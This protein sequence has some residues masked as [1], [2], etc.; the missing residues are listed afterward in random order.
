[1]KKILAILAAAAIALPALAQQRTAEEYLQRYNM[2]AGRLGADGVGIETLIQN[3]EKDFPEDENMLMAKWV[4]YLSKSVSTEVVVM[5]KEKY[6][7]NVPVVTL[8]DSLGNNVNYFQK[9]VFDDEM[10]ALASQALDQAIKQNPLNLRYRE[11]KISALIVYEGDSPDMA[12]AAVRS[13]IDYHYTSKPQWNYDSEPVS[14]TDFEETIQNF[15]YNFFQ[16]GSPTGYEAFRATAQKMID[17]KSKN[18]VFQN[19]LGS[20]YQVVK[21]DNKQALKY[22]TKVLKAD[23]KNYSA[24]KNCVLISRKQK[25]VK[26]EKKYLA[27]L[28]E[29]SPDE[30]ER[31]TAKARLQALK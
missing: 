18:V 13:L 3:W 6:L 28:A 27:L 15:C 25:N 23:P 22:Y 7:G 19:D 31:T 24:I 2:L 10:Y 20:Y 29:H 12:S 1:M 5:D 4:Y 26:S 30:L 8:K 17:Y 16:M 21:Q 11:E 14:Q 9:N